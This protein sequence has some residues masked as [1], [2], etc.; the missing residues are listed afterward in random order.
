MLAFIIGMHIILQKVDN[1]RAHKALIALLLA[2]FVLVALTTCA[3]I[4]NNLLIVK[5]SLMVSLSGGLL[6]QEMAAGLK[7]EAIN[8]LEEWP[9]SFIFLIADTAIVWRAWALWAENRVIKWMLLVILLADIGVNIADAV[10]DTK[11]DLS[12]IQNTVTLDWLSTVLNLAV[13]IVA[14]LLIAYRAW[15]HH[16]TTHAIL[17]S[18]RTPVEVI[19]LLM[20]ESGAIFGV[21]QVTNITFDAL[22]T[23]A[24]EFSPVDTAKSLLAQLYI[25]SAV[26]NPVALVILIHTGNTYEH[27]FHLEDVT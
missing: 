1:G 11:A 24:T 6:A 8:V 21:V 16:Q 14:T 12:F 15:T 13:N 26:L 5:L 10:V 9:E 27:S 20:I 2:A 19:L 3:A 23:H 4:A 22:D 18:K 7:G 25:Y 17:Q